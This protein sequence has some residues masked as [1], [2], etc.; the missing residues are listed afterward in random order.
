MHTLL[1][2]KWITNKD[3][4]YSTWNS[5]DQNT[6]VDSCSLLQGIFPTK[7]SNPG[8]LHCRWILYQLSHKGNPRILEW[9]AC[10]FSSRSS[11]QPR[12]RTGVL[13]TTGGFFTNWA[14]RE[15]PST[16]NSLSVMCQTGR[17]GVWGR[18]DTCICVAEFFHCSPET[19]TTLLTG[20]SSVQNKKFKV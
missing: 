12:N 19:S 20:Y 2:S 13:C 5:P 8:L 11:S 9:I 15:V 7:W 17:H 3:L 1:Y 10:P 16:W 14:I 18:M 6:G 4:L